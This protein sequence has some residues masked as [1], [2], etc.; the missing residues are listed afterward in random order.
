MKAFKYIFLAAALALL[1]G[2]LAGCN[3]NPAEKDSGVSWDTETAV[4]IALNGDSAS[5]E[6]DGATVDGTTVTITQAGAYLLS[7]TLTDGQV[8]VDAGK[9]DTVTLVLD[10]ASISCSTSAAIYS[11]QAGLTALVLNEGTENTVSDGTVYAYADGEDEPDA[12]IFA[13]DSLTIAGGGSLTVSGNY[14]NGVGSKDDLEIAGGVLNITAANDGLRGRDSITV[15]DGTLT[16]D[17]QGDGMQANNDEDA[18]KG[19]IDL[20]GGTVQITAGNDGVQAETALT[21][22]GGTYTITTGGGSANAP[23]HTQTGPGGGRTGG[24]RPPQAADASETVSTPAVEAQPLSA[25]SDVPAEQTADNTTKESQKGLKAGTALLIGGGTC[26]IDSADDAVHSN[27]SLTVTGGT[28]TVSTGDDGFHA[29]G[30]LTVEDGTIAIG[31]SYEGLEGATV[32]IK[33]GDIRLTASDDGINAAGGSDGETETGGFGADSFGSGDSYYVRVSGGFLSVDAGGDGID[34]NGDL[35]LEGGTILVNGPTDSGNDALDYQGTC[36]VTGGVLAA[37]GS[38][39]MAQAP[40][41]GSTQNVVMVYFEEAQA[42]GTLVNLSDS[43]G[44]SVL[45]VTPAKEFQSIVLSAPGLTK[46]E[47]YAVSTGGTCAGEADAGYYGDAAYSGGK[48]WTDVTLN[49]TV[50]KISSDGSEVTGGMGGFSGGRGGPDGDRQP[51]NGNAGSRPEGTAPP[52]DGTG[53]R[54]EGMAP[55][56]DAPERGAGGPG[57]QA[58]PDEETGGTASQT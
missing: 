19:W 26:T 10:G 36:T 30:A 24:G 34:S 9:D 35:F 54:P 20:Q 14:N 57:G 15:V 58:A 32:D 45:T 7:G 43:A 41:D 25:A 21:V 31:T 2:A 28:C 6:G 44:N 22:A 16:V 51:P 40:G 50:A 38:A 49:S 4:K 48:K 27:G 1:G 56:E 5:V 17:A 29:D 23:A 46:G 11:K 3:S 53:S 37:A 52:D 39:G 18:E 42:A 13:K 12:A 33:G 55:P 47:T 8:V